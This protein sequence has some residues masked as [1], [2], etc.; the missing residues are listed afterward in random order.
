M[1]SCWT[2]IPSNDFCVDK[3]SRKASTSEP[4]S[5]LVRGK[6]SKDAWSKL[7]AAFL[8]LTLK[9]RRG[10]GQ[11]TLQSPASGYLT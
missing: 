7:P 8:R 11:L 4:T 10:P 3:P 5:Y 1:P 6:I 2:R 9:Y